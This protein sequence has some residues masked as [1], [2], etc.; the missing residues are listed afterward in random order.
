M[1]KDNLNI[2]ESN[3][4]T[5][6][7]IQETLKEGYLASE[8]LKSKLAKIR[9]NIDKVKNPEIVKAVEHIFG[10]PFISQAGNTVITYDMYCSCLNL[11]RTLGQNK[12][13]EIL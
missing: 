10:K 5:L 11:I 9:I 3:G 4:A 6:V 12:A 13:Q 2:K 7:D 8:E 1:L